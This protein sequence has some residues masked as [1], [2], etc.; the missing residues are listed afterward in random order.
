MGE[1]WGGGKGREGERDA[2]RLTNVLTCQVGDSCA[3]EPVGMALEFPLD[4]P[5]L[6][7]ATKG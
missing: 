6:V 2:E 3:S 5:G 1:G 7:R 4:Q